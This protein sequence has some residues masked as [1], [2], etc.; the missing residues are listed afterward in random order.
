MFVSSP[1]FSIWCLSLSTSSILIG[2]KLVP[3]SKPEFGDFQ[4][5]CAL[6][7]AKEIKQPPRQI[8]QQIANQLEKD[9]VHALE[10]AIHFIQNERQDLEK[11]NNTTDE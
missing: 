5:N 9:N 2:S 7:L 11:P 4:I 10:M 8:A 3:A 6:A 1:I